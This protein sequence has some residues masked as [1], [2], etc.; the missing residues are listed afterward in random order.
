MATG[1][2]V[3]ARRFELNFFVRKLSSVCSGGQNC[4]PACQFAWC[5]GYDMKVPKL[6]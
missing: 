4:Q 6:S 5:S 3:W 1:F 2:H